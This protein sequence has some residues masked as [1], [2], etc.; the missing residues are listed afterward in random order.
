MVAVLLHLRCRRS[1][2]RGVASTPTQPEAAAA[3]AD[4]GGAVGEAIEEGRGQL[5]VAGEDLRPLAEGE[6][7]RHEDGAPLV[8]RGEEIE[9]QLAAGAIER[10][11]AELVEDEELDA[12][13]PALE[14]RQLPGIAPGMRRSR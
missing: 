3:G 5:L 2:G 12:L 10:D 8:A 9:E 14:P 6:I 4:D 11:E 7:A 13:E 1:R